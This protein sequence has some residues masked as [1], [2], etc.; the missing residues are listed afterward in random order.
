M[1]ADVER[2]DECGGGD[3]GEVEGMSEERTR[4]M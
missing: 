2:E 3:V 4:G 1:L